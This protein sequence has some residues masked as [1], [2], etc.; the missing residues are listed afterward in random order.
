MTLWVFFLFFWLL[1]LVF[2]FFFFLAAL[3]SMWDL[4]SLTRGQIHTPCIGST[5]FNHW[6]TREIP[7]SIFLLCFFFSTLV[8]HPI[9]TQFILTDRAKI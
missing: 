3:H 1:L 9:G 5:Q 6:T 4:S 8:M 7:R 2:F